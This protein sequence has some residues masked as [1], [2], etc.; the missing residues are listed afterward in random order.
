MRNLILAL[1]LIAV[2]AIAALEY[3]RISDAGSGLRKP[4]LEA[5]GWS[6][7]WNWLPTAIRVPMALALTPRDT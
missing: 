6:P 2:V 3:R 4:S 5:G 1:L 7:R